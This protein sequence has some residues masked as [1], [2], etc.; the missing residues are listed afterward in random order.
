MIAKGG[1]GD[2]LYGGKM[3]DDLSS[4]EPVLSRAVYIL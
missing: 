3:S 2:G 1:T 4:N